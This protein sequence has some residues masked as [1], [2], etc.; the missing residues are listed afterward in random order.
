VNG[1]LVLKLLKFRD[2]ITVLKEFMT[3]DAFPL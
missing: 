2:N 3:S 1:R